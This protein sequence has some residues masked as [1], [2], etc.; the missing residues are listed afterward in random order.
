VERVTGLGLVRA[1]L[2][3]KRRGLLFTAAAV[4]IFAAVF[5]LYRIPLDPILY[6]ALL[7]A[8]IGLV[9][10]GLD[11]WRFF[12][13]HRVL[14]QLRQNIAHALDQLPEP[15][16]LLEADYQALVKDLLQK[17]ARREAEFRQG[18]QELEEYYTLWAHQVKTPIAAARLL[19]Q[20]GSGGENTSGLE[21]ELFKIERYVEMVLQYLRVESPSADLVIRASSL[22]GIVRQ[23][24]RRY[25]P[26]FIRKRISLEYEG[27]DLDVLTD[28]K[29]LG[30]VLEQLLANALKYTSQGRIAIYLDRDASHTLVIEDTGMGIAPEDLPRIF[31]QGYTGYTGHRERHSTGIGLYLCKRIL[32]RL[33]HTIEVES[34]VGQGTRVKIGLAA[35]ERFLE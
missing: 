10:L 7:S 28:A 1:Y 29:W 31:E 2:R 16:D 26:L 27:I 14:L 11:F 3:G 30:F 8:C 34:K 17:G 20:T 24:V 25:A 4:V 19:L 35:P 6:A 12:S 21:L 13:R 22:D 33:G 32:D 18:L 15:G 23:A 5:F 9:L